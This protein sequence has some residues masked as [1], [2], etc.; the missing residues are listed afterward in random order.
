MKK[1]LLFLVLMIFFIS[2]SSTMFGQ[3]LAPPH[4]HE[5]ILYAGFPVGWT[6]EWMMQHDSK[7]GYTIFASSCEYCANPELL[8]GK[9]DDGTGEPMPGGNGG[10]PYWY[11]DNPP[12]GS[13]YDAF[14]RPIKNPNGNNGGSGGPEENDSIGLK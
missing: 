7:F 10:N 1:H 6:T 3:R 4:A 8:Y 11:L 2:Y 13:N 9:I 12:A 5:A 14:G